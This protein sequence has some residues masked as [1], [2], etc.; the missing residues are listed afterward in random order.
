[1][2]CPTLSKP[3][4][5]N[6]WVFLANPDVPCFFDVFY[7]YKAVSRN[8]RSNIT[9]YRWILQWNSGVFIGKAASFLWKIFV[10]DRSNRGCEKGSGLHREI[11]L[12]VLFIADYENKSYPVSR[13]FKNFRK[14]G[15][16]MYAAV[17]G[18][19]VSGTPV[20]LR[21]VLVTRRNGA[22]IRLAHKP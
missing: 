22:L 21:I 15:N 4:S 5:N 12:L 6:S 10:K 20:L 19:V 8:F 7:R 3:L 1:M 16:R 18:A 17:A 13:N 11:M 14:F 9:K 2:K